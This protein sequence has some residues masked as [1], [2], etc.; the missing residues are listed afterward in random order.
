MPRF[1]ATIDCWRPDNESVGGAINS[2][3][4]RFEPGSFKQPYLSAEPC[5]VQGFSRTEMRDI[6]E[7]GSA[8]DPARVSLDVVSSSFKIGDYVS[9]TYRDVDTRLGEIRSIGYNTRGRRQ[10]ILVIEWRAAEA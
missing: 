4:G 9:V 1:N 8:L 6:T 3:T 2:T 5:L 10:T 7:F